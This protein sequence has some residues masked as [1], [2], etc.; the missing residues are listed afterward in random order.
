MKYEIEF[1]NGIIGIFIDKIKAA[2][3]SQKGWTA[4]EIFSDV[5]SEQQLTDSEKD[6]AW[7]ILIEDVLGYTQEKIKGLEDA[8][9][10]NRERLIGEGDTPVSFKPSKRVPPT[11]H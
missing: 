5:V 6:I 4:R 2:R 3:K 8:W 7:C 11:L 9:Q 1:S 10:K